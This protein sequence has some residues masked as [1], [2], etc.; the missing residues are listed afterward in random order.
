MTHKG[1]VRCIAWACFCFFLVV[2]SCAIS[3]SIAGSELMKSLAFGGTFIVSGRREK[4]GFRLSVR[5]S[6]DS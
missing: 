2:T 3:L 5:G 4:N 6:E 1:R